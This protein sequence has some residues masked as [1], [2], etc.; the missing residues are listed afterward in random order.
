MARSKR[1]L[2]E[3]DSN[4]ESAPF[5][6]GASIG[7]KVE[8]E[9]KVSNASD[10]GPE[11]SVSTGLPSDRTLDS[12]R[13]STKKKATSKTI[14]S[15]AIPKN[16]NG[17]VPQKA[18]G[19]IWICICRPTEDVAQANEIDEDDEDAIEELQTCG[20][21]KKCLCKKPADDYPDHRWIM[22]KKGF[23]MTLEWQTEQA[24]RDQDNFDMYIFNDWSGY[25]VV[26]VMEII[27]SLC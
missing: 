13:R 26:E 9:N 17:R 21:G 24:K 19:R 18:D 12:F 4:A 1:T 23:E 2:A 16:K 5:A 7:K 25:G 8:K 14:T 11:S 3:V 15:T 27:A 20:G 22:T 6:K 10:K